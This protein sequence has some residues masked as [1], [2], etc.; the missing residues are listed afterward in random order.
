MRP[1]GS[2]W[3]MAV[4]VSHIWSGAT[5]CLTGGANRVTG[6]CLRVRHTPVRTVGRY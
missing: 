6:A 3:P 5:S 4:I 2:A 1:S